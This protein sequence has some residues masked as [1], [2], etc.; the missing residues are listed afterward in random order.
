MSQRRLVGLK[1]ELSKSKRLAWKKPSAWKRLAG[2]LRK[3]PSTRKR[4]V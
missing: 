1:K 2:R 4:L 3:E